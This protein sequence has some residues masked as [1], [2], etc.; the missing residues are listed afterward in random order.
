VYGCGVVAYN[1]MTLHSL[2][3]YLKF[4]F[5]ALVECKPIDGLE[6]LLLR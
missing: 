6:L 1:R 4:P 3:K 2:M 5:E